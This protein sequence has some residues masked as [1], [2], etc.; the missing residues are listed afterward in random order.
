MFSCDVILIHKYIFTDQAAS[1]LRSGN[2]NSFQF[3][4]SLDITWYIIIILAII[5]FCCTWFM[6]LCLY[7]R[8][9][10]NM[11]E[12]QLVNNASQREQDLKDIKAVIEQ[13]QIGNRHSNNVNSIN[14][15]LSVNNN[16]INDINESSKNKLRAIMSGSNQSETL[17]FPQ[18]PV[19]LP[20][21]PEI[22][23]ESY[24]F[25]RN[26]SNG[27]SLTVTNSKPE[28]LYH[29]K[30]QNFSIFSSI[31]NHKKSKQKSIDT[32]NSLP[33]LDEFIDQQ[34][35]AQSSESSSNSQFHQEETDI[36]DTIDMIINEFEFHQDRNNHNNKNNN[37]NAQKRYLTPPPMAQNTPP[38][39]SINTNV[40]L[41]IEQD[42]D[43]AKTM[44]NDTTIPPEFSSPSS[45]HH[46]NDNEE[47]STNHS[48]HCRNIHKSQS[49]FSTSEP[50][51][52]SEITSI[53]DN[54]QS[55]DSSF[56]WDCITNNKNTDH[57]EHKNK[58]SSKSVV[59]TKDL[60][61]PPP[62][63]KPKKIQFKALESGDSKT[64]STKS[65]SII[66]NPSSN[67]R[68]YRLTITPDDSC[69]TSK[70][71]SPLTLKPTLTDM[72]YITASASGI[73]NSSLVPNAGSTSASSSSCETPVISD[74]NQNHNELLMVIHGSK[75]ISPTFSTSN[76][77]H[78]RVDM[79][80]VIS[81]SEPGDIGGDGVGS[82]HSGSNNNSDNSN[83]NKS[84]NSSQTSFDSNIG[85]CNSSGSSTICQLNMIGLMEI[86]VDEIEEGDESW[87]SDIVMENKYVSD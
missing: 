63:Y 15:K 72:T 76:D 49:F 71:L 43:D 62:T 8:H 39:N 50:T 69:R 5:I 65:L 12:L 78:L 70:S 85:E 11:K 18:S 60:P 36:F 80:S 47:E 29:P 1:K 41:T 84:R 26:D 33:P 23:N 4:Q 57:S 44:S 67:E 7:K 45:K 48:T 53:N 59:K 42:H 81:P 79:I 14:N 64:K 16:S 56:H 28:G 58:I 83:N 74:L 51:E 38:P 77:A 52:L 3:L 13:S 87:I 21:R 46:N 19:Q 68:K 66:T 2:G 10:D 27:G 31:N 17:S 73:T 35:C 55:I 40:T 20:P 61:P 82:N 54:D 30:L 75:P 25:D 86:P 37:N 6:I 32:D 34:S 9:F 24:E 22:L